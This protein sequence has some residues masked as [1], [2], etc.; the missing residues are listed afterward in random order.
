MTLRVA[1][2]ASGTAWEWESPRGEHYRA[3]CA[4]G[5]ALVSLSYREHPEAEWTFGHTRH[6]PEG[7][8]AKD[9]A[10]SMYRDL[11]APAE[12]TPA[13]RDAMPIRYDTDP[14]PPVL[15]T[16]RTGPTPDAPEGYEYVPA[17]DEVHRILGRRFDVVR[18][19]A[20]DPLRPG[21][22]LYHVGNFWD[23]P[24]KVTDN[25]DGSYTYRNPYNGDADRFDAD[26]YWTQDG[27]HKPWGDL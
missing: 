12:F 27:E 16:R 24:T 17:S 6:V 23:G 20:V 13:E 25:G 22:V 3:T 15:P 14:E 21:T 4:D 5:S 8:T 10:E 9:V 7:R 26:G 19:T 2:V 1:H 11:M 18:P